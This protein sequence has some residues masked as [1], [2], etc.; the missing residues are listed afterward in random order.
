MRAPSHHPSRARG[1]I[2]LALPVAFL[3]LLLDA[4]AFRAGASG[5]FVGMTIDIS[6]LPVPGVNVTVINK[7]NGLRRAGES[8]ASGVYIIPLLPPGY[9]DLSAELDGFKSVSRRGV[10]LDVDDKL[11][12]DFTFVPNDV[13]EAVNVSDTDSAV[14]VDP[15]MLQLQL[16]SGER[17]SIISAVTLREAALNGRN[18]FDLFRILPGIVADPSPA[19]SGLSG[20]S[21]MNV[22]GT[23][24]GMSDLS[25]DGAT[26]KNTGDMMSSGV[27]VNPDAIAEVRILTSNF[28]AE[29]GRAG[30]ANIQIVTKSGT[31]EFHG[32]A[33]Y[34]R[35]HESLNANQF[36][37]KVV[38]PNVPRPLFRYNYAGLEAGGPVVIPG[39]YSGRNRLFY[40]WNEEY[41]AQ[42]FPNT[43]RDVWVPTELERQG[44]FSNAT[45]GNGNP[46]S[47]RDPLSNAPFPGNR[48]PIARIYAQGAS[49]LRFFPQPNVQGDS[50]YNYTSQASDDYSRREDV[51]RLDFNLNDSTRMSWHLINNR[52]ERKLP[53]GPPFSS[54]PAP[55]STGG[56]SQP[57][58]NIAATVSHI[59]NPNVANDLTVTR[60]ILNVAS[61]PVDDRLSRER[62]GI[63]TPL[64]FP[65]AVRMDAA[66]SFSFGGVPNLRS[67][68][69]STG[70]PFYQS[71]PITNISDGLILN[72]GAHSMKAGIYLHFAAETTTKSSNAYPQSSIDFSAS[73]ANP[74]DA[75]HPF[76][77]A[78]LGVYNSYSQSGTWITPTMQYHNI[79]WYLQDSWRLNRKL[80][81]DLGLRF[82][83]APVAGDAQW[84][85]PF[86]L[87]LYDAAR[88]PRLYTPVRTSTGERRAVDPS[89]VPSEPTLANTFP[90]SYAGLIVPGSGAVANG[91]T[92]PSGA[93]SKVPP[94][95]LAPRFGFAFSPF[96]SGTTVIR[97]GFGISYDRTRTSVHGS[98]TINPPNLLVTTLQHGWLQDIA[99]IRDEGLTVGAP[100]V[101]GAYPRSVTLPM[102]MSYSLGVQRYL[103]G[104]FVL[105]AAY[106]GNIQRHLSQVRDINAIPY[107]SMFTR[108]AQDP[109]LFSGGVVPEV[110][111]GLPASYA[112]AGLA[113]TGRYALPTNLRRPYAG[114]GTINYRSFDGNANYN[115]L[116]AALNR[117]FAGILVMSATYTWSKTLGTAW[118]DQSGI[119]SSFDIHGHDYRLAPFDRT[120]VF[121]AA[122]VLTLPDLSRR[123]DV[124]RIARLAADGWQISGITTAYS[125]APYEMSVNVA[126]AGSWAITGSD[127]EGLALL[128]KAAAS[129]NSN[130][131]IDPARYLLPPLG[132]QGY[133]SRQYLRGPG[134]AK[135]DIAIIKNFHYSQR[136]TRYLQLRLEMFNAL[137]HTLFNGVNSS[138]NIAA[139]NGATG[140]DAF[141][142][143]LS[144]LRITNNLRPTGSTRPI[145][146]YF[147]EYNSAWSNRVIQVAA[148]IYF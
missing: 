120:H 62:T 87:D 61:A 142:S 88:A 94:V 30:G 100:T 69:L 63:G 6:G 137:N 81:L 50:R 54:W 138:T 128:G 29:Y 72:R 99:G 132:S 55:L 122:Y 71:M 139:P 44:D 102:V 53:Y 129:T 141:S 116:Q 140:L 125:G 59:F 14:G 111:P 75:G 83:H 4:L 78:L 79:E 96:A 119:V 147:G 34:F 58:K 46:M 146:T 16:Q 84:S 24:S 133:G 19:S 7:G 77:N 114:F 82:I 1:C 17:S 66:P 23:R 57:G 35:R 118:D 11:R 76:A 45:D 74:L 113:F 65:E 130:L 38:T 134:L 121:S 51:F 108:E 64:L 5:S 22:N 36:F 8:N 136:D 143:P 107:G 91:T 92:H 115:S 9:Y 52:D 70:Y 135:F 109:S 123:F 15:G 60:Q 37:N 103:G 32:S 90:I 21:R 2:R 42:V 104:G 27:S 33:R 25:I 20:V 95:L 13:E 10:K 112:A 68:D 56:W 145:G 48:I 43:R 49:A 126:G 98:S 101:D 31:N 97:G 127:T 18:V 3:V 85:R 40:Y 41:Y 86:Y 67:P 131:Q 110:E 80:T 93:I 47:V 117:R 124:N 106:V 105:D 148:K 12:I 73:A 26:S 144:T 28:Q 89:A 39:L